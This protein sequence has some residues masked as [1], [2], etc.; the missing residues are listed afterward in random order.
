MPKKKQGVLRILGRNWCFDDVAEAT[1]MGDSTVRKCFHFFCEKFV[2]V[3]YTT[4]VHD[5][6]GVSQTQKVT[7]T[8][9]DGGYDKWRN[10]ALLYCL[11][12]RGSELAERGE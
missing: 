6:N 4:Y 5:S 12:E 1:G 7:W 11:C 9:C 3:N 10:A 2:A 8:I